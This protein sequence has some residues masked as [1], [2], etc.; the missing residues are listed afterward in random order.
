LYKIVQKAAEGFVL[1]RFAGLSDVLNPGWL[2]IKERTELHLLRITHKA[3]YDDNCPLPTT[4]K[5]RQ[6][7]DTS[8]SKF[9]SSTTDSKTQLQNSLTNFQRN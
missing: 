1:N 3:M 8:S 5:K 4:D 2:P 6:C 9:H 7:K